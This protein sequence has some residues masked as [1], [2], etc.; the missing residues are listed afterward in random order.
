MLS[1]DVVLFFEQKGYDRPLL[2]CNGLRGSVW[3]LSLHSAKERLT[4]TERA[5]SPIEAVSQMIVRLGGASDMIA[6][7][8]GLWESLS[9]ALSGLTL[10]VKSNDD[11]RSA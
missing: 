5:N 10:A 7:K 1:D 6:S 2:A 4:I 9:V 11:A 8:S 3:Y